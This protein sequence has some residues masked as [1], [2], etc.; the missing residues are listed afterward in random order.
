[1]SNLGCYIKYAT[2]HV[3][4]ND[5]SK[6]FFKCFSKRKFSLISCMEKYD[7]NLLRLLEKLSEYKNSYS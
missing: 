2:H 7:E 3:Q 4:A 5:I 6:K 1:M